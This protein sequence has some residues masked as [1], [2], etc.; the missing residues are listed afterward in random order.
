VTGERA[1]GLRASTTL[2]SLLVA[3]LTIEVLYVLTVIASTGR[4]TER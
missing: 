2:W 1:I 4:A 3:A